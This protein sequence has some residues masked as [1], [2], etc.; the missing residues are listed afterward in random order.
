M[1][2]PLPWYL[3]AALGLLLLVSM[4]GNAFLWHERDKILEAKATATQLAADTAAS[5]KVCTDSV[6]KLAASGDR[7]HRDLQA[8]LKGVAPTVAAMQAD[9]LAAARAKPDDPK[10]LCGSMRRYLQN[11]VKAERRAAAKAAP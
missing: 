4:A 3:A 2:N 8:A 1:T 7:R 10:D 9:V 11:A 5:A 6:D